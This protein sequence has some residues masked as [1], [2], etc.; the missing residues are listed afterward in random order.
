MQRYIEQLVEML[1][2]AHFNKPQP[3]YLELP[4]EMECLRD[5]ID[6]EKSIEEG[7]EYTMESI[8]GIEQIYFPPENRLSDEQVKTLLDAILKLWQVFNYAAVFRKGEFNDRQK[9]TQLVTHWKETVPK[10]RGSNGTYYI[11]LYDHDLW[12]DEND[13]CYLSEDAYW[14]K[15]PFPH[16]D[17][18][19]EENKPF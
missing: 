8:F 5:I 4:E 9:Y 13:M 17:W 2:E 12:W 3:R 1:Q 19:D 16:F 10:M 11:E 6:Y 18:E 15:Y 14:K 7:E